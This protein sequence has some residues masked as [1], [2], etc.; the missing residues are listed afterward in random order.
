MKRSGK[1]ADSRQ[2]TGNAGQKISL[3]RSASLFGRLS[4]V[5]CPLVLALVLLS[6]C[7]IGSERK[8]ACEIQL[9]R[10]ERE[11]TDLAEQ[12]ERSKTEN[13]QL[14][15]QIESLAAL[16]PDRPLDLFR[17]TKVRITKYTNFY[18]K[19]DDGKREKLIV[20]LQPID[21]AGDVVKAA[22]AVD[23]QLWN[24]ENPS[25]QA[26]LGEWHIDPNDMHAQW[27]QAMISSSYRLTFDIPASPEVLAEPLTV[28][29]TFTDYLTGGI[30]HAQ[31]AIDPSR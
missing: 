8:T 2:W 7:G 12:L 30:F 3:F 29:V 4:S 13:V 1:A 31:E 28:K 24:L 14:A 25:G 23:V 15:E 18:D 27:V 22:G 6:G 11:N 26:L 19:D 21:T 10:V 5:F 20:Y 17:L 9:E 16:G